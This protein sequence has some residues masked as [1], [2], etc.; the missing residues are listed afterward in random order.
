[1]QPSQ[2]TL[3]KASASMFVFSSLIVQLE[4]VICQAGG[5]A[6]TGCMQ[7]GSH[8]HI[9]E[10]VVV[11]IH[12]EGHPIQVLMEF[13]GHC[14]LEGEKLQLVCWVMRFSLAQAS[15][16]IGYCSICAILAGLVEDYTQTRTT[17]IS[18]KLEWFGEICI[19]KNGCH[20]ADSL[21]VIKG[22]LT[23]T[24]PLDG[25]LPLACIFT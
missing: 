5:P 7:L 4:I 20:G 18:V 13:L 6:M 17:G 9:H 24:V 19:C 2:D 14:P 8:K 21:Q 1:M 11:S 22:L 25:S 15:T 10:G 12:I 23:P 3:D 16:G